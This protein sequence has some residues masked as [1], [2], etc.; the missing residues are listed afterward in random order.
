M[1]TENVVL[2][3]CEKKRRNSGPSDKEL[4]QIEES[5]SKQI[6]NLEIYSSDEESFYNSDDVRI[7]LKSLTKSPIYSFE[8]EVKYFERIKNGDEVAKNEFI[9]CNLRLVVSIAKKY[10]NRGLPFLDL[11]QEGNIGLMRAVEKFDPERG[12]KFS[13]YATWWIRQGI[14]RGLAEKARTVRLPVHQVEAVN[15]Y[16]CVWTKMKQYGMTPTRQQVAEVLGVTEERVAELEKLAL[17]IVLF[18]TPVGDDGDSTL[19]EFIPSEEESIM[20]ETVESKLLAE[21]VKDALQLTLTE[22]ERMVIELRFGINNKR[23]SLDQIGKMIGLTRERVR[24]I[25][26]KAL[27]KLRHKSSSRHLI[28]YMDSYTG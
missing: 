9:E 28:G 11:I 1:Y 19:E 10:L 21:S 7:Y 23:H 26:S 27:K 12:Y 6:E 4:Q 2:E 24:Q 5:N 13:T 17:D 25:E 20:H 16:K 14:A 15:K 3:V 8:E 22:R 18:S